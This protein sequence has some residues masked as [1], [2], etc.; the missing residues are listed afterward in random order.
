MQLTRRGVIHGDIKP[1]NILVFCE[2]ENQYVAK[3]TDFGYS[4]MFARDSDRILMPYSKHWTAPE[5]H[6]RGFTPMQARQMDAYSFGMLCLWLL[7]DRMMTDREGNIKE[8]PE[9]SEDIVEYTPD[10]TEKTLHL[11][12][13][14][15]YSLHNLFKLSLSKDP[16]QRTADFST[17]LELLSCR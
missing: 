4:T 3:V 12:D 17:F 9:I 13:Q 16:A 2:N 8:D 1:E 5:Y 10:L 7:F 11:S 15:N 6:H 14:V